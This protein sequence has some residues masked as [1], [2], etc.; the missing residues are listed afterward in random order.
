MEKNNVW[1]VVVLEENDQYYL[2]KE[3][4][5]FTTEILAKEYMENYHKFNSNEKV[6]SYIIKKTFIKQYDGKWCSL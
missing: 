3:I 5:V 1:L 4:K 6:I 2:T